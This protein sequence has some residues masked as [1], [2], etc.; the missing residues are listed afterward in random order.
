MVSCWGNNEKNKWQDSSTLLF[1]PLIDG[2]ILIS[3]PVRDISSDRPE[4][5]LGFSTRRWF[6][7]HDKR[8]TSRAYINWRA[9]MSTS[10]TITTPFRTVR[11]GGLYKVFFFAWPKRLG[12]FFPATDPG[13]NYV[14]RDRW[15]RTL[16]FIM[17]YARRGRTM[18]LETDEALALRHFQSFVLMHI[19][20]DNS[21]LFGDDNDNHQHSL[22]NRRCSTA[23]IYGCN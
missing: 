23:Q 11:A 20:G 2:P 10:L 3:W 1:G 5:C 4:T 15:G 22:I 13:R 12:R 16:D 8:T 7:S 21:Y 17:G 9:H 19:F 18:L 6:W 14:V